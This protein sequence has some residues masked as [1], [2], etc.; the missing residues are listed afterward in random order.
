MALGLLIVVALVAFAAGA[1]AQT[2]KR[3]EGGKTTVI[4]KSPMPI[5][6]AATGF[7]QQELRALQIIDDLCPDIYRTWI[8]HAASVMTDLRGISNQAQGKVREL[9]TAVE[10][11]NRAS[12]ILS[13]IDRDRRQA[14]EYQSEPK[15]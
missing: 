3:V 15:V 5:K 1:H 7:N 2:S 9:E 11:A 6:E 14:N 4:L 12:E 10:K 13:V 8:V